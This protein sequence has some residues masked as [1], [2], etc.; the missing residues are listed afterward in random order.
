MLPVLIVCYLRPDKLEVLLAELMT[1]GRKVFVYIDRA[2]SPYLELNTKVFEVAEKYNDSIALKIY[3]SEKNQGVGLGVPSALNWV[4]D[5]EEEVIVLEDDCLPTTDAYRFFDD[6]SSRLTDE[7]V[8][9]CGTSPWPAEKSDSQSRSLSISSYPLIWGWSTNS[10]SWNKLSKLIQNRT[11]H[12]RVLKA[13]LLNPSRIKILCFFYA[14]VIRVNKEKLK[15]W[16]SPVALEMLLSGYK[17][18]IADKSLV[19]NSGQDE[20]ASH[21]TN[22]DSLLNEVVSQSHMGRASSHLDRSHETCSEIDK[23]IEKNIYSLKI[24]HVFSP[25]KALIGY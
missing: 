15:A 8:M 2:T 1:S 5:F 6:Q 3:W 21:F 4:F 19:Q 16:D 13:I 24:R 22:P 18:I 17:A 7:I 10:K 9:A 12:L 23:K 25:I 20:N 11:P 14:A